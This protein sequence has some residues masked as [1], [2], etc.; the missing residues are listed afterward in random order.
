[1][2]KIEKVFSYS[3]VRK[4]W[5]GYGAEIKAYA[6]AKAAKNSVA[7]QT[8]ADRIG[9][10]YVEHGNLEDIMFHVENKVFSA[11]DAS[12]IYSK[13]ENARK[14]LVG[15][16][17]STTYFRD[18]VAVAK[19]SRFIYENARKLWYKFG[20]ADFVDDAE[21][22][23][24]S[25]GVIDDL[26]DLG[27][28]TVQRGSLQDLNQALKMNRKFNDRVFSLLSRS[29]G[30]Q[31]I[32][33]G[34]DAHKTVDSLVLILNTI[35][36]NNVAKV[37][38][39]EF[40]LMDTIERLGFLKGTYRAVL[41]STGIDKTIEGKAFIDNVL[42]GKFG[43]DFISFSVLDKLQLPS[44]FP[45]AGKTIIV[46]G[47]VWDKNLT[48]T[49][50]NIPWEDLQKIA[51]DITV[52]TMGK[53]Q[54]SRLRALSVIGGAT[55]STLSTKFV[56]L[57][58]R[59]TLFPKLGVRASID[60]AFMISLTAPMVVLRNSFAGRKAGQMMTAY[61][62]SRAAVGPI[63]SAT[64]IFL[65]KFMGK[66]FDPASLFD[67]ETR[68]QILE[69]VRL[70]AH[71]R[72]ITSEEWIAHHYYET[73]QTK[74]INSFSFLSEANRLRIGSLMMHHPNFLESA[75]ASNARRVGG[76]ATIDDS[77]KEVLSPYQN[78]MAL[79]E[80]KLQ[81]GR[82]FTLVEPS[83]FD[84][85]ELAA[86]Q[87]NSF[88][89]GFV[90]GT[91][92]G[93]NL[94]LTF[95]THNALRT[96]ADVQN[97]IDAV[98]A[99]TK[100]QEQKILGNR[101]ATIALRR[102][103]LSDQEIVREMVEAAFADMYV[104][105]H[106]SSTK[107][108]ADLFDEISKRWNT[109]K[110]ITSNPSET[111]NNMINTLSF[112]DYRILVKDH[113]F[114][115][116]FFTNVTKDTFNLKNEWKAAGDK[117][118]EWMDRT[119][120]ALVRQPVVMSWYLH[121]REKYD[122]L[123]AKYTTELQQQI[124]KN[125]PGIDNA[126][127]F[128]RAQLQADSFFTN[129]AMSDAINQT[130]KFVD[131]PH[132]R[133][134]LASS[135][136]NTSRFFRATED[137][138]RR[139]SRL[140]EVTPRAIYRM[141][142]LHSGLYGTG[143]I[144]TDNKGNQYIVLPGDSII[145]SALD[146]ALRWLTDDSTRLVTPEFARSSARITGFN[147]SFQD[148]AGIPY[149]SGP[150]AGVSVLALKS[151]A[152]K[153]FPNSPA[154]EE[155]DN[156]LLG[157]IGDNIDFVKAVVPAPILRITN[158]LGFGD[159]SKRHTAILQAIAYNQAYG[160]GLP[161]TATA[162]E[163]DAYL[164]DIRIS[165]HNVVI[166]NT[167]LG[168]ILPFS[169]SLQESAQLPEY[170]RDSG[171]LTFTEEYYEIFNTIIEKYGD[172]IADPYALAEAIFV[173][174]N[175][176]KLI[177]TVSRNDKKI[178]PYIKQTTKVRDWLIENDSFVQKY[179]DAAYLFVP[180]NTKEEVNSGVYNWMRAAG[181]VESIDVKTYLDNVRVLEDKQKYFKIED[182]L[183]NAL[184]KENDFIERKLLIDYAA[185]L[186]D[187]YKTQS[188]L[189]AE[190]IN[191]FGF[192]VEDEKNMYRNLLQILEDDTA[193]LTPAQKIKLRSTISVFDKAYRFIDSD[194][195]KE[196]PGY[197][198]MKSATKQSALDELEKLA[199]KD[200]FTDQLI[201]LVYK[202]ILDFHSRSVPSSSPTENP[203]YFSIGQ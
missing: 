185:Q 126:A 104:R 121:Y 144:E 97:A 198:M 187:T 174:K 17:D 94:G 190:Y 68:R 169:T 103:G 171:T 177:Y 159:D 19:R 39:Q 91:F 35:M 196:V 88:T 100:G 4:Y 112:D 181:L 173:G 180:N 67:I 30:N 195:M 96:K 108:N 106:G 34:D 153:V 107:F 33:F 120:T 76:T 29:A 22:A 1:M 56:D 129:A 85:A 2:G 63:S 200:A 135:V 10:R 184:S 167:I 48:Q 50:S 64:R 158:A 192:S 11:D 71:S 155:I 182:D 160:K 197:V 102:Q 31:A 78:E 26:I 6:D 83:M 168:T 125:N 47:A 41:E 178:K 15:R 32:E 191:N 152:G 201:R 98:V 203:T 137:M 55:N 44:R 93:I 170:V 72:N 23:T 172:E 79:R 119:N 70:A 166:A 3:K 36:P 109:V 25:K 146:T 65:S 77:V 132:I 18:S 69:D 110:N 84:D 52:K 87:Y 145:F 116:K 81:T 82:D 74:V 130:L 134:N 127:A 124:I 157:D 161:S 113:L 24:F 40:L 80:L 194:T 141:R 139:V 163:R 136:R 202:P 189:L 165:A 164:N 118:F 148:D 27:T 186:R 9:V 45:N 66:K 179:G 58:S 133:T 20:S 188:P 162:Q 175:P 123:Q 143:F 193:P 131:N 86:V 176:G 62:G 57:W 115:G 12:K 101:V 54:A 51:A 53:S 92:G 28:D 90:N 61:T 199:Y 99:M 8:I 150:I 14:I 183:N 154:V 73:L 16:V 138:W 142:L 140:K 156:V 75:S 111:F 117:M 128:E 42:T 114:E 105:F 95:I 46:P 89:M 151:I 147:P 21:R 5:D 43:E 49:I 38:A 149:L 13:V 59:F 122:M 60:E 37:A 7:M